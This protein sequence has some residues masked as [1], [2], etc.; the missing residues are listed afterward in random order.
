[1]TGYEAVQ[2]GDWKCWHAVRPGSDRTFCGLNAIRARRM[3]AEWVPERMTTGNC[4]RCTR[5]TGESKDITDCE[6]ASRYADQMMAIR[7]RNDSF[8]DL[9]CEVGVYSED[10]DM[11]D[12]IWEELERRGETEAWL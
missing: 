10:R 7:T 5:S 11:A 9:L 3:Y 12:L 1:M 2:F 6:R 8:T 4:E